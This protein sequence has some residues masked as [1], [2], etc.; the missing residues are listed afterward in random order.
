MK[1]IKILET[2]VG[3]ITSIEDDNE[4]HLHPKEDF[5]DL[6]QN[7]DLPQP[8]QKAELP[9]NLAAAQDQVN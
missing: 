2:E 6:V 1:C 7:L 4:K 8:S 3:E 5:K 9:L